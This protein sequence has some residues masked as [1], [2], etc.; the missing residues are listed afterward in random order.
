[1]SKKKRED[2]TAAEKRAD[3]A[4]VRKFLKDQTSSP[5][6]VPGAAG[7]FMDLLKKAVKP[8]K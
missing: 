6:G 5:K 7:A 3:T 8:T 2:M 1:M 4:E